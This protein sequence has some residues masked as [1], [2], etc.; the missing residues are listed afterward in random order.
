MSCDHSSAVLYQ[1]VRVSQIVTVL[2]LSPPPF[3]QTEASFVLVV[4][5]VP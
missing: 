4:L 1:R 2:F 5:R 3:L